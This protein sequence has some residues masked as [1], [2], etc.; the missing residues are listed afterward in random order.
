MWR[1]RLACTGL[2]GCI[3]IPAC[4]GAPSDAGGGRAQ[5]TGAAGTGGET[6]PPTLVSAPGAPIPSGPPL[7]ANAPRGPD[8][9]GPPRDPLD[10]T[11]TSPHGPEAALPPPP[12]GPWPKGK[13]SCPA[14]MA[15]VPGRGGPFCMHR[16]EVAFTGAQGNMD[17]GAQF[18]DGSTRG[19][20][21]SAAGVEPTTAISWYQSVAACQQAGLHLCTSTEWLDAC[22]GPEGRA[23]PTP[24]GTYHKGICG[25][26]EGIAAKGVHPKG[27]GTWPDC[28]TPDGVY[29]MLGNAWEW[30]DPGK[31][32]ADG[33]PIADKHGAA[34]YTYD[35]AGCGFSGMNSDR[36]FMMGT[37]GFRCCT[38]VTT[39]GVK[40]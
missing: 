25:V 16:Y 17:Q 38:A 13:G 3:L 1:M 22:V 28:H 11:V 40:P 14:D 35:A 36:P 10:F 15:K 20:L 4:N 19:T 8:A 2:L 31:R 7:P 37:I 32:G 39:Q 6:A 29:D 30:A 5:G 12:A 24:D 21:V 23:Y 26:G 33:L 27:G 18:P 9:A 34:I